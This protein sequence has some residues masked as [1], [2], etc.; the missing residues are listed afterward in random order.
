[1][2]SNLE[3]V[4]FEDQHFLKLLDNG[5]RLVSGHYQ[6][7]LPFKNQIV[8]LYINAYQLTTDL[9]GNIYIHC[10]AKRVQSVSI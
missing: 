1:M 3:E 9:S 5:T 4:P 8:S 6:V 2:V 7:P 10:V